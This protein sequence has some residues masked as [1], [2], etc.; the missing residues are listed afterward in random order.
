MREL[1]DAALERPRSERERWLRDHT[2]DD[3]DLLRE[4]FG[5]LAAEVEDTDT[6]L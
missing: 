4:V 3:H 5:L 1:L 2:G 6:F